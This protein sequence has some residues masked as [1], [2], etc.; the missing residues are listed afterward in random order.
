L[1]FKLDGAFVGK[2]GV[3]SDAVIE[4]FDVVEDGATSFSEGG[5]ALVVNEFVFEA[6]PEAGLW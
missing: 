5:E 4:S 1:G 2:T 3:E 6:A